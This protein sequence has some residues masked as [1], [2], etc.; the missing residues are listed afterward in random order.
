MLPLD[1]SQ[2]RQLP[3]ILA[4]KF[5]ILFI[6]PVII[7]FRGGWKEVVGMIGCEKILEMKM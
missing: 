1:F 6:V 5:S 7:G 2:I 3:F 4:S